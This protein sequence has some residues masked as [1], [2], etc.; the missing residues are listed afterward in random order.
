[1]R[2]LQ[3]IL[4]ALALLAAASAAHADEPWPA[5]I[6]RIEE[7]RMLSAMTISVPRNRPEGEVKG[8]AVLRVHVDSQGQ[9]R[10]VALLESCGSTAHDEAALHAMRAARFRP[11]MFGGVPTDV[12]LVVP[13]HLPKP[14]KP[15]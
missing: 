3:L 4:A 7:M 14:R 9:V 11:Y 5:Q 2:R 12:T 1:M 13:L 8:P 10:R 6:V 15:E